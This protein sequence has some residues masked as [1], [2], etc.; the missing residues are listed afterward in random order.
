SRR[1]RR[2]TGR[3]S[4]RSLRCPGSGRQ[5]WGFL[6]LAASAIVGHGDRIIRELETNSSNHFARLIEAESWRAREELAW[7]A[8]AKVA[9]E[10]GFD[11]RPGEERGVDFGVV[12][13]R[14]RSAIELQRAGGEHEVRALQ[15]RIS[16]RDVLEH[17]RG[18]VLE[19]RFR[20]RMWE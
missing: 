3:D 17:G 11:G 8:V 2:T 10:I 14:H 9:Q 4:W 6:R 12:E 20:V 13:A 5:A 7:V 15:R 16:Q 19:P 18:E 1:P